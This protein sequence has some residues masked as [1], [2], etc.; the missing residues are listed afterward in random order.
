MAG[1]KKCRHKKYSRRDFVVGG[2]SILAG[3]ALAAHAPG[4]VLTA[5]P[6]K[7]A[8][9]N[10]YAPSSG[11]LVYDSRLCSG[12]QSCMLACSLVHYGETST[13]LSRI[14][15][16]RAV[17]TRYPYD[18]QVSVCRQCPD[19]LC[20]RNCPTGA[21]HVSEENGNVRMIDAQKCI[22]C[23]ACIRACPHHPH[24]T[25]WNPD[26]KKSTKCDLCADTPYFYKK[27]GSSG[28][29][30][31]VTICP[32]GALKLV[33]E[34]PPQADISGYDVNLAPPAP[35]KAKPATAGH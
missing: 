28:N 20:V 32:M 30:A 17:L 24:R 29:Q 31:C 12:C 35:S 21:C 23:Q 27:G 5:S 10:P 7:P 8:E 6:A 15:I 16:S 1:E 26:T 11:Y 13:S 14:Q 22:G 19:P 34:M 25:I 9:K 4:S 18:I 3:G 33:A 2:G